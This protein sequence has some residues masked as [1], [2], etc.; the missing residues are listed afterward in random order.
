MKERREGVDKAL[1]AAGVSNRVALNVDYRIYI[2]RKKE[3]T[4]T[5]S[6]VAAKLPDWMEDWQASSNFVFIAAGE[7]FPIKCHVHHKNSWGPRRFKKTEKN[8]TVLSSAKCREREYFL[9]VASDFAPTISKY[10]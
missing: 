9:K 7:I 1:L 10:N 2:Q 3:L 5:L 4:A 8:K 6:M